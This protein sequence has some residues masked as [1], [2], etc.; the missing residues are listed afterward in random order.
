MATPGRR[1]PLQPDRAHA[2]SPAGWLSRTCQLDRRGGDAA[3]PRR[4]PAR[5]RRGTRPCP[6]RR[7]WRAPRRAATPRLG[8]GVDRARGDLLV[9]DL[10]AAGERRDLAEALGEGA[11]E[12]RAGGG[13]GDGEEARRRAGSRRGWSARAAPAGGPSPRPRRRCVISRPRWPANGTAWV[14]PCRDR[15]EVGTS[16]CGCG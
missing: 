16:P 14:I 10:G 3:A 2:P 1:P 6:R 4:R 9:G 13:L 11:D 12:G 15:V 7:A 5:S 8:G